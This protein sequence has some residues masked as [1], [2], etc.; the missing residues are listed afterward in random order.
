MEELGVYWHCL[1]LCN[2]TQKQRCHTHLSPISPSG[3]RSHLALPQ[4]G[5]DQMRM[6]HVASVFTSSS[7]VLAEATIS[8]SSLV[9][10]LGAALV[11]FVFL[12]S[13]VFTPRGDHRSSHPSKLPIF[14]IFQ[15]SLSG[16]LLGIHLQLS[17]SKTLKN[18]EGIKEK[19]QRGERN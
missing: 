6:D 11:S 16:H 17:T 15:S 7:G 8:F 13:Q 4:S 18:Y 9:A 12:L 2:D 19:M 10:F 14:A 3:S 5:R 1:Q